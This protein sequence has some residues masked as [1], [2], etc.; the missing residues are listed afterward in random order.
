M[1]KIQEGLLVVKIRQNLRWLIRLQGNLD[2]KLRIK[3]IRE[4]M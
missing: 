4:V 2:L 3:D 1:G